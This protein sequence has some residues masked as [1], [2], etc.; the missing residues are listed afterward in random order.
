MRCLNG[1]N[2]FW[3][4]VLPLLGWCAVLA[5][6]VA[7][8]DGIE[9]KAAD[10]RL[11]EDV[12]QLNADFDVNVPRALEDALQRGITLSFVVEFALKLPRWYWFDEEI[13]GVKQTTKLSFNALTR[14]YLVQAN[15]AHKYFNTLS[16]AKGEL[17]S[18]RDWQ[19]IDRAL[20]KKKASYLASLRMRLDTGQLPKPVQIDVLGSREWNL[21]SDW[22]TWVL[23]T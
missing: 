13:A 7:Q 19:V 15:S 6:P 3:C 12:Y 11:V 9:V 22:Y 16:E 21:A 18:I 1:V 20:V 14:Q 8:A 17:K 4:W 10:L 2:R 23:N 5:A